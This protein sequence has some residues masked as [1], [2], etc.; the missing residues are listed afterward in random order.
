M[1]DRF[2][3]FVWQVFGRLLVGVW[4]VFG[5][6]LQVA[7]MFLEGVWQVVACGLACFWKCLPGVCWVFCRF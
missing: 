2:V 6:L 3:F 7:R 4:K 5:K 1:F